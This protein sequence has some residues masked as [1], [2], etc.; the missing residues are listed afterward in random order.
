MSARKGAVFCL[1]SV[2]RVRER[3]RFRVLEN[4]FL[5]EGEP[6]SAVD[7]GLAG[8]ADPVFPAQRRGD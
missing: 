1:C 7:L 4:D 5:D 3:R 6:E 2:H 8:V